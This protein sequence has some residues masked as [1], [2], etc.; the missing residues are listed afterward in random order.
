MATYTLTFDAN[1][2][3]GA[4][5]TI[6]FDAG[7]YVTIPTKTPTRSGYTFNVWQNRLSIIINGRQQPYYVNPG[8]NVRFDGNT[9]LL[10]MWT[11]NPQLLY[12]NNGGSG[13][14]PSQTCEVGGTLTVSSTKPTRS[15]YKFLGW[16]TRYTD[17]SPTYY[18]GDRITLSD[19]NIVL[20]AV[21]QK[22]YVI[23]Y[24]ANGGYGAP[25]SAYSPQG[26]S[27]VVSSTIPTRNGYEF[28][29]WNTSSDGTGTWYSSGSSMSPSGDVTLYAIW[30]PKISFSASGCANVPSAVTKTFGTALTL[31]TTKPTRDGYA[32]V[33]W[34]TSSSGDGTTYNAGGTVTASMNASMTLYAIMRKT[35]SSPNISFIKSYRCDSNGNPSDDAGYAKVT[36]TWSVDTYTAGMSENKGKVTIRIRREDSSSYTSSVVSNGVRSSATSWIMFGD[37]DTDM[38]YIIEVTVENTVAEAGYDK[39]S[40]TRTDILTRA[41]F[42]IDVRK[43]GKAI[44]IGSAAPADGFECG[45]NAQ[46][47]GDVTILGNLDADNVRMHRYT[48]GILTTNGG[49]GCTSQ[50]GIAYGPIRFVN[51][52]I[53]STYERSAGIIQYIGTLSTASDAMPY[54]FFGYGSGACDIGLVIVRYASVIVIPTK[55]ISANTSFS[56]TVMY[57]CTVQ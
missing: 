25:S 33:S 50:L 1:G 38:Q 47:D 39:L 29:R 8:D 17:T 22:L 11:T 24:N 48:S 15:G 2:G 36:V 41:K 30:N 6:T 57:M 44:G 16:G 27:Y 37:I 46:F 5:S 52:N 18:A 13:A 35:A 20:Y 26:S 45:W 28:Y 12:E 4:P 14:P 56:V 23:T 19:F 32:F 43:G 31:P 3:S 9:T 49:W 53:T 40:T 10:A 55:A 42:V 34:N 7:S 21:W 54:S 51:F